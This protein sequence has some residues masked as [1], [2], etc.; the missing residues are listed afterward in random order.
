MNNKPI[1]IQKEEPAH[2]SM[3]FFFLKEEG[4]RMIQQLSGKIW[5]DYNPH[6]PGVTILEQLCYAL[7]DLGFRTD[8]K[9]Q[10]ILNARSRNQRKNLNSTFF[11]ASEILPT[12]PVSINDYR[13]LIIDNIHYVK[14]AWIE[15][16]LDNIQ[17][18]RGL[19]RVLLQIDE[20]F[21]NVYPSQKIK[22]D[23]FTL[24]NDHRNICEDIDSVEILNTDKIVVYA[25]LDISSDS[26]AEEI[27]SEI[28]F[29]LE[30]YINPTIPYYTIEELLADG[31][32]V[33][34]ILNGPVPVHGV[35]KSEDLLPMRQEVYISK[36]I[37]IITAVKGVRRITYFSVEKDGFEVEGDLIRISEK[38]YPVLDMDTIDERWNKL[39]YPIHFQRGS[40]NYELDL[41]TANQLLYSLYAKY[42]KG[43]SM[44]LLYNEK[45]YPSS[46]KLDEISKYYSIQNTFPVTYGLNKLGLPNNVMAT[47]ERMAMI[48]QLRGYLLLFEQIMSNYL[49]QLSNAG[50]LFSLDENLD[51]TYFSQIPD[52]IPFLNEIIEAKDS[53]DFQRKL[54][55]LMSDF[56]PFPDRRNRI[57]DHLLARFGEQFTTDF[58][59][60]VNQHIG[61]SEAD[62]NAPERGLID[63][64]IEFLKN[65]VHLGR[66]RS[67]G[68]NCLSIYQ[69]IQRQEL[70]WEAL[71]LELMR[72][73]SNPDE[74]ELIRLEYLKLRKNYT[75]RDHISDFFSLLLRFRSLEDMLTLQN[76]KLLFEIDIPETFV[77]R[78]KE[79]NS[80]TIKEIL[81]LNKL[82][83]PGI[84]KRV[85]LLLNI[86]QQGNESILKIFNE[87]EDYDKI[88]S[89]DNIIN[90]L[91]PD[92]E[93]GY[94]NLDDQAETVSG[95][96][97]ENSEDTDV[98]LNDDLYNTLEGE[99]KSDINYHDKF[100][101][102]AKDKDGLLKEIMSN[103]VY[104]NNYVIV[105]E[106]KDGIEIF[107]IYYRLNKKSSVVKIREC[108]SRL[109][110]GNEISRIIRYLNDLNFHTEGMHVIEHVLLRPQ[111]QDRYGFKL[112]DDLGDVIL[113]SPELSSIEDQRRIANQID[114][115]ASNVDNYEVKL[116]SDGTYS[117]FLKH[118]DQVI[119]K[120]PELFYISTAAE[121]KINQIIDYAN[122]FKN[123]NY[124]LQM[125][126]EIFREERPDTKINNEFYSLNLSVV[127][128]AWPTR[129]QSDDFKT[130][131]KNLFCLNAPVHLEI[132]FYW[133]QLSEMEDF[134]NKYYRWLEERSQLEPIQSEL[135]EKALDI[136]ELLEYYKKR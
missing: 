5:T 75:L 71:F 11:D 131:F 55:K 118:Y 102:R 92:I 110:A 63:S 32:P 46:L 27:L 67:N 35:I 60:R 109:A 54:E 107:G 101:F 50:R 29:K 134:E 115:I 125:K 22:N 111:A 51:K 26:I 116:N 3:D 136:V 13:K 33:D 30:E 123:N 81:E 135:D 40:L 24:F 10:D 74:K 133:L 57:L 70:K 37:E 87:L 86:P 62:E 39:A 45:D 93:E 82:E 95:D 7:S 126:T 44:K 122:S 103:G 80:K 88:E 49:A 89:F 72:Q 36:I 34:E 84:K 48:K 79:I 117:L 12:N 127:L 94:I 105:P 65:Y 114:L 19:Y 68:T 15:P 41:N 59:I 28:L 4:I 73:Y 113:Y 21:R 17:G 16:V 83:I 130:L 85:A 1:Q 25:D 78:F 23:V 14:N 120:S 69:L 91:S 66:N 104:F 58:L 2:K 42:K 20:N 53:S 76:K 129:F 119:A 98:K 121:N 132:N 43:Y 6:D 56:D 31:Y 97:V 108:S 8:F 77:S 99:S 38:T 112:Y 61:I 106:R 64:K 128:P 18:I 47:R 124:A 52:D 100:Y 96:S 90:Y 9:I